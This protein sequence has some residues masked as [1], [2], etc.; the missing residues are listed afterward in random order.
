MVVVIFTIAV[1]IGSGIYLPDPDLTSTGLF[2]PLIL[3]AGK[4]INFSFS[5]MPTGRDEY[6]LDLF[7]FDLGLTG[8][9]G[10]LSGRLGL[11]GGRIIRAF[12]SHQEKGFGFFS[13]LRIG[14]RF[15]I[16]GFTIFPSFDFYLLSDRK[17]WTWITGIGLELGYEIP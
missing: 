14:P 16:S 1:S 3:T 10:V 12:N 13:S 2:H 15:P 4:G 6:R 9:K 17:G 8:S 7:L 11:G 5:L